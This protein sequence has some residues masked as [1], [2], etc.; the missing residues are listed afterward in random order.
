MH[1]DKTDAL[2]RGL[3]LTSL[4]PLFRDDPYAI[5]NRLRDEAPVLEDAQLRDH[6]VF[7]ATLVQHVLS[8]PKLLVDPRSM[9]PT[10]TRMMRG[11]DLTVE[12][13][14]LHADGARHKRLRSLMLKAFTNRRLEA[15]R[16]RTREICNALFDAVE[17]EDEF[18]FV[19]HIARPMPTI[20][21]TELLGIDESK[22]DDFKV[23]S[24]RIIADKLNPIADEETR[25]AGAAAMT[26]VEDTVTGEVMRRLETGERPDDLIS[27]MMDA[28]TS[29]G[30]RFSVYEI[31][32]HAQLLLIAGNQTTT[33]VMG[34]LVKN[35]TTRN[36]S[37]RQIVAEPALIPKAIEE[38]LRFEP[39]IFSTERITA[40]EYRIKDATVPKGHV[41]AAMLTA[42]NHDPI[43]NER[44]DDFDIRRSQIRHFAFGG[45]VHRCIGAPLAKLECEVLLETM[46][47]RFPNLSAADRPHAYDP[48]PGF[49]GLDTFWLRKN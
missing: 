43:L 7:P 16:G 1:D 41:I 21:I 12:T 11:E 31:S 27:G 46:V 8:D 25:I 42:A 20:V 24:D 2:P 40:E 48:N 28:E 14:L 49:R 29:D 19:K 17:A 35:L 10:S 26:A 3:E 15:F 45:G 32:Q 9:A 18:D 13:S 33:D 6:V 5:L 44:P 4:S 47:A 30:Q 23:W 36:D 22:H 37:Y 34:T 39:P 38:S